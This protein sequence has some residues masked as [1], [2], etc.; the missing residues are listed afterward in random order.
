MTYFN[1][2][3]DFT[4]HGATFTSIGHTGIEQLGK[5]A[6]ANAIHNSSA[7]YD[8]PKCH[9]GTRKAILERIMQWIFGSDDKDALILWLY[10]PA[11]AGKSAI[12]QSIAEKCAALDILLASFFF[13]RSDGTRNHPGSLVATIASQI[14][15]RIPQIASALDAAVVRDPMIFGKTLDAQIDALIVGPLRYLVQSGFFADP[16]SAPRLFLVDGLDE[17]N[18]EGHRSAV[19]RAI[20]RAIQ[21]HN[22]P[23]IFLIS[24]RPE[25]DIRFSF[26]SAELVKL[27]TSLALDDHYTADKDIRLFLND[28]FQSIKE[29]HPM[30]RHILPVWPLRSAVDTLATKSSGQFIYAS[31][32]IK[33]ISNIRTSPPRQLDVILG[34]HPARSG[35]IPFSE[36]DA[37]YTHILASV[38]DRAL[39]LD[40][41]A[42]LM[43]YL[44]LDFAKSASFI[45][46]FLG[47]DQEDIDMVFSSL[48]SITIRDKD[49]FGLYLPPPDMPLRR[50]TAGKIDVDYWI[51][52]CHAS[53]SDFLADQ[54][55]SGDFHI[56]RTQ[57][58]AR[59]AQK[60]IKRVCS[61][62]GV[63]LEIF[64]AVF[65]SPR[66]LQ[67]SE[68]LYEDLESLPI[69]LIWR[70]SRRQEPAEYREG[71]RWLKMFEWLLPQSKF[72]PADTATQFDL[73]YQELCVKYAM[74]LKS[75]INLKVDCN[76]SINTRHFP[77]L[78]ETL[79]HEFVINGA[80]Y[81]EVF[82]GL[83]RS[84]AYPYM[85]LLASKP[86]EELSKNSWPCAL[87]KIIGL[88]RSNAGENPYIHTALQLLKSL[89]PAP[90][91]CMALPPVHAYHHFYDNRRWT[92][93]VNPRQFSS[94]PVRP[95]KRRRNHVDS[96]RLNRIQ[97]EIHLMRLQHELRVPFLGIFSRHDW[98]RKLTTQ[99]LIPVLDLCPKSDKLL[100]L[101]NRRIRRTFLK[102]S[103]RRRLM[104]AAY[105]YIRRTSD[106]GGTASG[107]ALA[108]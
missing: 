52:L 34:I 57:Y 35:D 81:D 64:D 71:D 73:R 59:L 26:D 28:S 88:S 15:T 62:R 78:A 72:P 44:N 22:L 67:M 70:E 21:I 95:H 42:L 103:P 10:G 29:T 6:N 105:R 33:Y 51:E 94:E 2:A 25:T 7:R 1:N 46:W 74:R 8:P 27:W 108:A 17:C 65:T 32:V 3:R 4:I 18:E 58:S 55:R 39:M 30:R 77:A 16:K 47:V 101:I 79:A 106:V 89:E 48:A 98:N 85:R 53:L 82:T 54:K 5:V 68:D 12:L 56:D 66:P 69:E 104:D 61:P 49:D 107:R 97:R 50:P 9:P 87:F 14:A 41:L 99:F 11:G 76:F 63:N 83:L 38:Q 19:L 45:S 91:S 80:C 23:F 31:T 20:A 40:I 43:G 96:G 37:L 13:S 84:M 92:K 75:L 24:S 93:A 86:G 100:A 36:I 90:V 102:Y 60:G